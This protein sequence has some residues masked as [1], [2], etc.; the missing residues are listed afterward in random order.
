[1]Y[2]NIP[3][4]EAI[5]NAPRI[6]TIHISIKTDNRQPKNNPNVNVSDPTLFFKIP[7]ISDKITRQ[8]RN[9]FRKEI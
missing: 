2:T 6:S 9:A 3:T 7:F 5:D 4:N 1:M 8:I